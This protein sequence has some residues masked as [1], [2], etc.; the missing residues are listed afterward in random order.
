MSHANIIPI[1]AMHEAQSTMHAATPPI[2]RD[3]PV[4]TPSM[5]RSQESARLVRELRDRSAF[6]SPADARRLRERAADEIERLQQ[7]PLFP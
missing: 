2:L 3:P 5:R 4:Q 1:T 7:L 6:L